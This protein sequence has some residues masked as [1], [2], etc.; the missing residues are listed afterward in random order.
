M[1]FQK[2]RGKAKKIMLIWVAEMCPV[3]VNFVLAFG[4]WV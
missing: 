4:I 3:K 2:G 1:G